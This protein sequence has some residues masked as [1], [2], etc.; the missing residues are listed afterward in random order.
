[1]TIETILLHHYQFIEKLLFA[2]FRTILSNRPFHLNKI[3]LLYNKEAYAKWT[4]F[5][6]VDGT[7]SFKL[8]CKVLNWFWVTRKYLRYSQLLFMSCK[9]QFLQKIWYY[10]AWKWSFKTYKRA[11]NCLAVTYLSF[12]KNNFPYTMTLS[13]N[14]SIFFE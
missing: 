1:M 2:C 14:K 9:K 5:R 3:K 11:N 12:C 4:A 13:L 8:E 10:S 6:M 7:V